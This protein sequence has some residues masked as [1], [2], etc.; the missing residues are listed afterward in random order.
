MAIFANHHKQD[1]HYSLPHPL[2]RFIQT[3]LCCR[4][5]DPR[6]LQRSTPSAPLNGKSLLPATVTIHNAMAKPWKKKAAPPP[7]SLPLIAPPPSA[8]LLL[9]PLSAAPFLVSYFSSPHSFLLNWDDDGNYVYN[10][11][12]HTLSLPNIVWYFTSANIYFVYEPLSLLVKALQHQLVGLTPASIYLTNV[13]LHLVVT[14]LAYTLSLRL[15]PP[16]SAV[17]RSAL[18]LGTLCFSAHPLRAEVVSWLSCQP[19]LLATTFSLL[20]LHAS[21]PS[22]PTSPQRLLQLV[23]YIAATLFKSIT[24]PLLTLPLI[25]H[26]HQA[27]NIYRVAPTRLLHH[28]PQIIAAVLLAAKQLHG[29]AVDGYTR[30]TDLTRAQSAQSTL[31]SVG[32]YGKR[33]FG[34]ILPAATDAN[35]V[36]GFYPDQTVYVRELILL[37]SSTC[38]IL[39]SLSLLV[40]LPRSR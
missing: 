30:T 14:A 7:P 21:L 23:L 20:Y 36:A 2:I 4:L 29:N 26:A 12:I 8:L 24:I 10:S 38:I 9:L 32:W 3:S 34:Q 11:R 40:L 28:S 1:G 16:T 33:V 15:S 6:R 5:S 17:H 37:T 27:P 19:Y 18:F 39:Y 35:P 31:A 13:A 22:H 25:Y